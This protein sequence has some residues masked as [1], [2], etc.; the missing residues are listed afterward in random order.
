LYY[1]TFCRSTYVTLP[2]FFHSQN[3]VLCIF[4]NT[5][6]LK[7]DEKCWRHSS[8]SV[9][10]SRVQSPLKRP[11]NIH[12]TLTVFSIQIV[13]NFLCYKKLPGIS[14]TCLSPYP[15]RRGVLK[16]VESFILAIYKIRFFLRSHILQ[17]FLV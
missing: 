13:N 7:L 9:C 14:L 10:Y 5:A 12:C 16:S 4:F 3:L 6:H 8:L 15:A 1:A 17:V 2:Y 11:G